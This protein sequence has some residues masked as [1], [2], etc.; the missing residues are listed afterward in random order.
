[1][2]A[3]RFAEK[4]QKNL[5]RRVVVS[6]TAQKKGPWSARLTIITILTLIIGGSR[7]VPAN[8]VTTAQAT[9][10]FVAADI[11]FVLI[12]TAMVLA[13]AIPGLALFYGGLVRRKNILS[14]MMQCVSL[15][16]LMSVIWLLYGYSLVF[17]P[18]L[19]YSFGFVGGFDFV[20]MNGV[21]PTNAE[22]GQTIPAVGTIPRMSHFMFQMMFFIITPTL[23][24]GAFAERLRFASVCWFSVLWGT[25][26][27]CPVAHWIWSDTGW[28]SEFNTTNPWCKAFDFAGGTVVHITSGVSALICAIIIGNRLGFRQ[29]P[30]PPH[31]LTYTALGAMLLWLGW[32]GFNAGSALA[33]NPL[34]VA[35]FTATHMAAASGLLGWSLMEWLSHGRVT[36][37]GA[38]SGAVA[39][40]VVITPACGTCSPLSALLMGIMG[41][42]VCYLACT[43]L[44]NA[45]QY[46]DSLD[47]FG[48]HGVGGL[49]GAILTGVF[50]TRMMKGGTEPLGL[51]DGHPEQ[52]LYQVIAA[53]VTALYAAFISVILLKIIDSSLGLRVSQQA[54]LQGL[55]IAEHGEEGYIFH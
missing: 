31:N 29:E 28:F 47:A 39:G 13:M 3:L 11:A 1:M 49:L 8:D 16:G 40:L 42:A 5:A 27:Y 37:L 43:R 36:L 35:A 24:C 12:A 10:P 23:I 9:Q 22:S 54:E 20:A 15:T 26:V 45:F 44:K 46:D 25:F 6:M 38:C 2:L 53:L 18:D 33:A 21:L 50:A 4:P 55:D 30:M 51:I 34:A 52:I 14:I 32:F 48:I 7:S 41:G 19:P 17:A